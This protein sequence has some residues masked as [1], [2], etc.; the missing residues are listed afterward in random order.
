MFRRLLACLALLT[1]LA[2]A[3]APAQA[4]LVEAEIARI[5]ARISEGAGEST[6]A[7]TAIHLLTQNLACIE[8]RIA[9]PF[10]GPP[11]RIAPSVWLLIDRARE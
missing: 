3:G 2:A 4:H 8:Q 9:R 5:E 11:I 6:E 7:A 1:G 10:A